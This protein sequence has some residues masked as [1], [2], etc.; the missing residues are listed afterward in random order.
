MAPQVQGENSSE[1]LGLT[2]IPRSRRVAAAWG[3]GN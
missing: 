3:W 2:G 1:E